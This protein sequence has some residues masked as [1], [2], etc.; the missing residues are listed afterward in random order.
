MLL[1]ALVS[2]CGRSGSSVST[3]ARARIAATCAMSR[4]MRRRG[5]AG[6]SRPSTFDADAP[7]SSESAESA[8]APKL[9]SSYSSSAPAFSSSIVSLVLRSNSDIAS[10]DCH[11]DCDGG[12]PIRSASCACLAARRSARS[13]ASSAWKMASV[14]VSNSSEAVLPEEEEETK[15]KASKGTKK[16]EEARSERPERETREGDERAAREFDCLHQ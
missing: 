13:S 7:S 14:D 15:A 6:M 16:R 11:G 2:E 8:S 4:S 3:K 9:S 10:G 12:R 1:L 5:S